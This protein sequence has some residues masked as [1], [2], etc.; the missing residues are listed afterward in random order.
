MKKTPKSAHKKTN[1]KGKPGAA[2][3]PQKAKKILKEGE[4]GGKPLTEKQKGMF[5]A[6]VGRN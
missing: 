6:A 2:V 3:S 4:I 1:K 5:G